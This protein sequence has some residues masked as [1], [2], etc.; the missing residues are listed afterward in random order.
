MM[1]Y[2]TGLIFLAFMQSYGDGF[3]EKTL[4]KTPNGYEEISSLKKNDTVISYDHQNN[5]F[6]QDKIIV[7][8]TKTVPLIQQ[9][10]F[11]T[12]TIYTD[13]NQ[14]F[15]VQDKNSTYWIKVKDISSLEHFL[16]NTKETFSINSTTL[17]N[18]QHV[19][20]TL[21][22]KKYHN[23]FVTK[24]DILTHNSALATMLFSW[25]TTNCEFSIS[26]ALGG[27][28]FSR[29]LTNKDAR[30]QATKWGYKETKQ[31]KINSH[32]KPKFIKNNSII[33]PD[34]DGH[35]GG[36]WKEFNTK[37]KKRQTLDDQGN[38]IKD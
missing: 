7:I 9:T 1:R 37:T 23:F 10:Y 21:T 4:V 15:F 2:L 5:N 17:L 25:I 26:I 27:L 28:F 33:T 38:R 22:T 35:N 29:G 30:K 6:V 18:Q 34:A 3:T 36:V 8:T 20:Y 11:E 14:L 31:S 13:P 32:G 12:D 19:L 16:T 24:Q